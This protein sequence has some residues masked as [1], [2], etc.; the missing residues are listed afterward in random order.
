MTTL[1]Y[2]FSVIV[3]NI[4]LLALYSK[5]ERDLHYFQVVNNSVNLATPD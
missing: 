3:K 4:D 2:Y 5:F 1:S